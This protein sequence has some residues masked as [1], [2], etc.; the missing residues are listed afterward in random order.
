MSADRERRIAER[1]FEY[2]MDEFCDVNRGPKTYIGI[3]VLVILGIFFY[4]VLR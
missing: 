3:M 4:T 2:V 1:Q